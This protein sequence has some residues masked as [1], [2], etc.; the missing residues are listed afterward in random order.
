[1]HRKSEKIQI[2]PITTEVGKTA[3][4]L[5]ME[6][7]RPMSIGPGQYF[8]LCI[9]DHPGFWEKFKYIYICITSGRF[10]VWKSLQAHPFIVSWWEE[11]TITEDPVSG[12]SPHSSVRIAGTENKDTA[13][14]LQEKI[15]PHHATSLSFVIESN[16]GL[17]QKLAQ[18]S[19]ITQMS[20]IGPY[21]QNLSLERYETV[22]LVAQGIGIASL[23]PQA[24]H[25]ARWRSYTNLANRKAVMTRKL[26]IYWVL[27]ANYQDQWVADYLKEI[28][29]EKVCNAQ[30][31]GYR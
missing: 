11:L 19:T 14:S 28:Y 3:V 16:R 2:R 15:S 12:S 25:L 1:L 30:N 23:L 29:I 21:G 6:L 5:R 7:S 20:L 27:E 4:N 10:P 17:S 8:Y 13:Q 26:D 22:I 24:C 31:S 9:N 18:L